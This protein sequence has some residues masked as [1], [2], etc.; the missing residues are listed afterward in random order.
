MERKTE[1]SCI[2]ANVFE[3]KNHSLKVPYRYNFVSRLLLD[4]I[5]LGCIC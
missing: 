2:F 1:K 4:K 3:G 5:F